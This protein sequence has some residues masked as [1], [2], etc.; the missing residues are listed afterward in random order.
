[1]PEDYLVIV[2]DETDDTSMPIEGQRSWGEEV[3]KRISSLKEVRLSVAQ[4]EKNMAQFLHL[5]RTFIQIG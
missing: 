5:I 1:M 4:P 2:T 3:R